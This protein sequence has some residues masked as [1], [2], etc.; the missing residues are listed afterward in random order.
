L[1]E[2]AVPFL[3]RA[4]EL[5]LL[6]QERDADVFL[7]AFHVLELNGEDSRR[8]P[9]EARKERLAKPLR[10]VKDGILLNEHCRRSRRARFRACLQARPRRHHREAARHAVQVRPLQKLD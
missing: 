9:L 2:K 3:P 7:Y 6:K 1:A 5:V 10:R 4:V 8:E